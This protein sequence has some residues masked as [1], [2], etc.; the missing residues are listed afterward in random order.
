MTRRMPTLGTK[1]NTREPSLMFGFRMVAASSSMRRSSSRG[2]GHAYTQYPFK[3][4]DQFRQLERAARGSGSGLWSS[5]QTGVSTGSAP[6]G[7]PGKVAVS[8]TPTGKPREGIAPRQT[9]SSAPSYTGSGD[10]PLG[11]SATAKPI[12]EGPR[13]GRYHI[14]ESGRKV[15]YTHR[16]AAMEVAAVVEG[17]GAEAGA[18][19]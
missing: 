12:Y 2:Y 11:Y 17:T 14:S 10:A 3:Y 18:E 1:T 8:Q 4:A 15:Y 5:S 7:R 6:S 9:R 13:G 19:N 16:G